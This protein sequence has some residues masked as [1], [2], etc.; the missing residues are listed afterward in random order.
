MHDD[1]LESLYRGDMPQDSMPE[2]AKALAECRKYAVQ[3]LKKSAEN[4]AA[5]YPEAASRI[6]ALAADYPET[7]NAPVNF[8]LNLFVFCK[9]FREDKIS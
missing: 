8:A 1:R 9:S 4:I 5:Y 2:V 6:N 7:D 3:T